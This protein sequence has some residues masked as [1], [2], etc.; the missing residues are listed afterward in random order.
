MARGWVLSKGACSS[1][2]EIVNIF[3][4]FLAQCVDVNSRFDEDWFGEVI[5]SDHDWRWEGFFFHFCLFLW[6]RLIGAGM[7]GLFSAIIQIEVVFIW[8]NEFFMPSSCQQMVKGIYPLKLLF[9][10]GLIEIMD[11]PVKVSAS[12]MYGLYYT[13]VR[14]WSLLCHTFLMTF[15]LVLIKFFITMSF[16]FRRRFT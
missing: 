2:Q 10:H 16:F 8:C 5:C 11:S 14:F 1:S 7:V 12:L 6:I 13:A 4:Y 9:D 15:E 3:R